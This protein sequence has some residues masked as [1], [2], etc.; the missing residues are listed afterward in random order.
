MGWGQDH[1]V[2]NCHGLLNTH[3]DALNHVAVNDTFYGGRPVDSPEV[4]SVDVIA[5]SGLLARAVYVGFNVDGLKPFRETAC[6]SRAVVFFDV[7]A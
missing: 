5:R 3:L 4:G 1:L 6:L 7:L 2:L